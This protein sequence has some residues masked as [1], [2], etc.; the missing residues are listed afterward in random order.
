MVR[1]YRTLVHN[2]GISTWKESNKYIY[3][4]QNTSYILICILFYFH[5]SESFDLDMWS[6][7]NS[8][9]LGIIYTVQLLFLDFEDQWQHRIITRFVQ[10]FK[11]WR[12]KWNSHFIYL[13]YWYQVARREVCHQKR[14]VL[15]SLTPCEGARN[16]IGMMI[17]R[18]LTFKIQKY[19]FLVS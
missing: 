14:V 6:Y 15:Y 1:H 9:M 4:I 2:S 7:M 16:E 18:C 3:T 13:L 11:S 12:I 19:I 17:V 5:T 10:P 8:H